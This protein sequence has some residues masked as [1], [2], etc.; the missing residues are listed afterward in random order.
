MT[1]LEFL[2]ARLDEDEAAA[3]AA[4][5]PDSPDTH[6]HWIDYASEAPARP[7]DGYFFG[8]SLRTLKKF[9]HPLTGAHLPSVAIT[10][11]DEM[12][13]GVGAHIARY[14]PARALREI[15]A[16][17]AILLQYTG[18]VTDWEEDREAPDAVGALEVV[19][20]RMAGVYADHADYQQEWKP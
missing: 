12:P 8:V 11:A 6:W 19:I 15:A 9:P 13:E 18:T 10:T 3:R 7:E 4:I 1:L 17:H 14:D 5:D 20:R 2:K 16:K